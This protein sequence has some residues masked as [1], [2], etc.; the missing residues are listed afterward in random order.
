MLD[1]STWST[2]PGDPLGEPWAAY[3]VVLHVR[4]EFPT[5]Q[6]PTDPP[7]GFTGPYHLAPSVDEEY[8]A[9]VGEVFTAA[10]ERMG[11][12]PWPLQRATLHDAKARSGQGKHWQSPV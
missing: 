4:R 2:L 6:F 8:C 7:E 5:K 11:L 1:P 9:H 10:A 12:P 3:G